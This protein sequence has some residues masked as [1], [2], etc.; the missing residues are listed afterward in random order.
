[1]SI[2]DGRMSNGAISER[3]RVAFRLLVCVL[4]PGL[5]SIPVWA[6]DFSDPTWPCVQRKVL[7]LGVGQMWAGPPISDEDL[8]AWRQDFEAAALAP[9]LAARRTSDEEVARKISELVERLSENRNRT[10]SLV[11]AGVFDLIEHERTEI[12]AGIGRYA[13]TQIALSQAIETDQNRLTDMRASEPLDIAAQDQIEA[14]EDKI[15]WD[16]RIFKDRQQSLS[17]VCET[18]VILERRAFALARIIQAELE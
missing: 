6:A 8:K 10:L 5:T 7:R 12:I 17:F 4:I 14:L 3:M 9:V 18:P 16:T 15:L 1:M 11:F 2:M 13:K